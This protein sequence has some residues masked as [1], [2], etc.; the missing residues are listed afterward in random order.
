[1]EV[2]KNNFKISVVIP[3]MNEEGNMEVLTEK[4][5]GILKNYFDYEL[6]FVDDGSIDD[7]LKNVKK[8]REQ[9]SK[10]HFLSFSRNFGHQNALRAVLDF[11]NGD[12]VI[13]MDGDM[14]HPPE[15]IPELIGKWQEGFDIVYTKREDDPR[16]PFFKRITAQ[17]FYSLM[18]KF[19][20]IKIDKGAADFRLLDR[21]VVEIL[22]T[23]RE[24]DIFMRGMIAWLGFNQYGIAYM[25]EG[26]HWG[27][28]KYS[29]KKM[30]KF[31]VTG[32]TS[33]SIKPL[34]ISMV[35]GYVMATLAFCYG[36]YAIMIK[37]FTDNA[38]SGWTSLLAGVLFIGGMQMIMIGILGEYVGKL[39]MESK[40][41]PN[42]I[43]K[44]KSL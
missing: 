38:I 10:I 1:M 2:N 41:R 12:C 34:R 22:K 23:I 8:Q 19:S 35:F 36:I 24:G 7:T 39:F 6:L 44:E 16:V 17:G 29:L 13:S 25:P 40:K 42:Y 9:N 11:A 4:V 21:S 3:V 14:Q 31:A 28:T 15:L 20:D 43:I 5:I 32:I 18:N 37:I 30:T 27:K 26:R 33:F